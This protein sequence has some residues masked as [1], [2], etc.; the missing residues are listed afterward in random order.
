MKRFAI[1]FHGAEG[2]SPIV[3]M[4]NNFEQVNIVHRVENSGSEPF[5]VHNC[6]NIAMPGSGFWKRVPYLG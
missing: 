3:R 4:L 5:D 1:L 2:T 6:G